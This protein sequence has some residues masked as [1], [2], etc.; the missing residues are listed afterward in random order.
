MESLNP[1]DL[2]AEARQR[3]AHAGCDPKKLILLNTGAVVVLGLLVNGLNFFLNHQIGSTGGL[4]GLGMRSALQTVQ[5]LMSYASTLVTPFWAAGL[6]FCFIGIVRD[7][8]VGPGSMLQGFRRFPKILSFSLFQGLL[9]LLILFPVVYL[10]SI[11]Y[12][13]TPLS[14]SFAEALTPLMESGELIS[15]SGVINLDLIPQEVLLK[16]T[17]PII[18][19]FLA[20]YIPAYLFLRYTLHMGPYLILTDSVRG[21]FQAIAVSTML[22]RGHRKELFKLDLSYW[23]YY[24]LEGLALCTLYLDVILPLLRIELPVNPTAAFFL[25]LVIYSVL[26]LGLHLWKKDEHDT[27]FVLAYECIATPPQDTGVISL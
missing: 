24:V 8:S 26:E 13:F 14:S 21:G 4:S 6:L 19:V 10:S 27:A 3:L 2:K 18:L 22:M 15:A 7:T 11:L 9:L 16:G 17:L 5:S 1:K 12:M 20:L 23:W 25:T